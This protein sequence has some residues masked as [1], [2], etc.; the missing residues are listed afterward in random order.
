MKNGTKYAARLR[1]A[2]HRLRQSRPAPT[3]PEPDDPLRRL[4]I[5]I[6]GVGG[7][8]EDAVR[9]LNRALSVLVDW[10]DLR[11]SSAME[12]NKATGNS[13]PHGLHRCQQLIHALQSIYEKEHRVSLDRLR[14]MGRREAREYL[15][16]LKGVDE[17]AAASVILWS[18]GGHAIPVNDKLMESLRQADLIHPEAT[19]AEVQAFL[20]RHV[21]ANDAKQFCLLMRSFHTP[22]R[23]SAPKGKPVRTGGNR[24]TA[25]K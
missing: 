12:V 17:H 22:K 5:A 1:T 16:K 23:S 19:R 20:E 4:A 7:G 2:Y 8:D 14:S 15:G 21:S 11:V 13:I 25:A 6:L 10:N 3:I 9:A 18:F 24:R